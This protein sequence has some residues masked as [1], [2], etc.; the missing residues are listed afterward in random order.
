MILVCSK[1]SFERKN[2]CSAQ[3][4]L[5]TFGGGVWGQTLQVEPIVSSTKPR[6][7]REFGGIEPKTF[8]KL[9]KFFYVYSAS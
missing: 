1:L 4:N 8:T 9:I 7:P 6:I 2:A 3:A 5:G